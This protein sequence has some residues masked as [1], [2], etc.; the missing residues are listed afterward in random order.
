MTTFT[1][2]ACQRL[3]E[4]LGED[5][6]ESSLVWNQIEKVIGNEID[7]GDPP[8]IVWET[9]HRWDTPFDG[10]NLPPAYRLD[11]LTKEVW[12]KL[13]NGGALQQ[14]QVAQAVYGLWFTGGYPEASKYLIDI[15]QGYGKG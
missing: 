2:E 11:D 15:L 9:R 13:I 1:L 6:P 5:A 14:L 8:E 7:A 12:A 4:V 3:A 10:Y